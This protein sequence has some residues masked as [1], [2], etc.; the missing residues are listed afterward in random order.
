MNASIDLEHLNAL[1]AALTAGVSVDPDP[2]RAGF[3]DVQVD[4]RWFYIHIPRNLSRV[5]LISSFEAGGERQP[6]RSGPDR[7]Y[8]QW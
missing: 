4:S 3:Y 5:Y 1:R 8:T 6:L 2:S 7:M